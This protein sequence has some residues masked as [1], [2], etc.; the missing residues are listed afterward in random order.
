MSTLIEPYITLLSW[1]KMK[2]KKL[3]TN[4]RLHLRSNTKPS[5]SLNYS[6]N[7]NPLSS[8]ESFSS[9][10]G[11]STPGVPGKRPASLFILRDVPFPSFQSGFVS[12]CNGHHRKWVASNFFVKSS[13]LISALISI[14]YS[15]KCRGNY[16]RARNHPSCP[17]CRNSF[18]FWTSW[19]TFSNNLLIC[20][21]Y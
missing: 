2:M 18:C 21:A 13:S 16:A 20:N 6:I 3:F 1:M 11:N 10:P 7:S 14:K 8:S 4:R 12:R 9:G 19:N 15:T 5:P 17:I